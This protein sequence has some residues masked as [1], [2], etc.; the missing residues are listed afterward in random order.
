MQVTSKALFD[1]KNYLTSEEK[2][3]ATVEK[4]L[5]DTKAFV[6]FADGSE[7]T[8]ETVMAYKKLLIARCSARSVNSMLAGINK[9]LSFI[10]KS[11]IKV[12]AVR[13]QKSAFCS[14][15]KELTKAEYLRLCRAAEKRKNTRLSLILQAVC[16]TGIRISELKYITVEAARRGEATVNCKGKTRTIFIVKELRKSCFRTPSATA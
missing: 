5:R 1:F 10:G 14:E 6:L 4:Y 3:P 8:K 11:E 7:P 15:E 13:L 2:S 12:K 9:F 16:G